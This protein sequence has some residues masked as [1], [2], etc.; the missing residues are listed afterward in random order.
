M[1]DLKKK[2]FYKIKIKNSLDL[3][4][5]KKNYNNSLK[6]TF[7]QTDKGSEAKSYIQTRHW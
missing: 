5:I 1:S 4:N 3:I 6:I 2:Y 7:Y